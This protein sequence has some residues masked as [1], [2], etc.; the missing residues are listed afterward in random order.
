M[1]KIIVITIVSLLTLISCGSEKSIP[2]ELKFSKTTSLYRVYYPEGWE[3]TMGANGSCTI[4]YNDTA[5]TIP[6]L[7]IPDEN[8]KPND[9]ESLGELK[10]VL[11]QNNPEG[12]TE[13]ESI[14]G[15]KAL[16]WF[17]DVKGVELASFMLPLDGVILTGMVWPS[18]NEDFTY[19]E[20]ELAR[21]IVDSFR[22]LK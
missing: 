8:A 9:I 13:I 11:I 6:F 10:D 5:I 16:W 1:R 2:E 18:Q 15:K 21:Q 20:L 7:I 19:R 4:S 14:S 3:A 17:F 12:T 22:L